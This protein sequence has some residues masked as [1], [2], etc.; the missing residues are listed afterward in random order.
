MFFW[1]R[2][3]GRVRFGPA[4]SARARQDGARGRRT[5][6][7][8]VEVL[9]G[10]T[11]L[12]TGLPGPLPLTTRFS[13]GDAITTGPDGNLWFTEEFPAVGRC[14]PAGQVTEFPVTGVGLASSSGVT[15]GPDGNIWFTLTSPSSPEVV[16]RI[17]P[18]G[19]ITEF[20]VT[21]LTPDGNSGGITAGPDGNLWFTASNG[22]GRITPAGKITTF[23]T[24]LVAGSSPSQITAGPDGNLWFTDVP[25][26]GTGR[27]GR[28]TPSGAITEFSLPI[29]KQSAPRG[30]TAGPDGN[31]WFT[32]G[33]TVGRSTP[34]GAVKTFPLNLQHTFAN[35]GITAG[36]DGTL[37]IASVVNNDL[38][39]VN[40]RIDRITPAGVVGIVG[41]GT[42]VPGAAV[43]LT[44]G[45]DAK[46][47]F[48]DR[49]D[50]RIY[51][52]PLPSRAAPTL[53]VT[54]AGG[55]Y[56]GS[57]FPAR[58]TVNGKSSLE[59]VAPTLTYYAGTYASA[60]ALQ[61]A[62]KAGTAHALAG[63]PVAAGAYTV[64]ASFAGSPNYAAARA[65][66]TFTIAK[67]TAAFSH[68]SPSQAIHAGT[69][70]VTLSGRLR[71]AGSSLAP[72][73]ELV[74]VTINGV[75]Q[76]ARL[77]ANGRFSLSFATARLKRGSYAITYS[78][79]GDP[80]FKPAS[81]AGT[82]L[83]VS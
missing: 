77:D 72:Q 6:R 22:I 57:A 43:G 13:T 18:A 23:H 32:S 16:C 41:A 64:V 67:A 28:I 33:D 21:G 82:R 51:T 29:A 53:L 9:E 7:P 76:T 66:A 36:P 83:T 20:P 1:K 35:G 14:T 25:L 58:A 52:L 59:G 78:Y 8:G 10:R 26:M 79:A 27:I 74:S 62:V 46:L 50:N 3:A 31:V 37:Y 12:S 49:G 68:P 48:I 17:T 56:N 24:G 69:A 63:A 75:T 61:A 71:V 81:D 80:N 55:T 73:G 47:W 70:S 15:A 34:G 11:L 19:K 40:N 38:S 4:I 5:S 60:A 54:D 2:L 45:P 44:A 30:I 65:Q 42:G 39:S